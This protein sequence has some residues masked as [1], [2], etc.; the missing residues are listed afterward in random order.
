MTEKT[1]CD[2]IAKAFTEIQVII[3]ELI[4]CTPGAKYNTI[5]KNCMD[6]LSDLKLEIK[7]K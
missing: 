7:N 2:L 1:I 4:R 3:R 5:I 6:Q